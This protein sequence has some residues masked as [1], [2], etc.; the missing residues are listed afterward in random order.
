MVTE[1][2]RE[3]ADR[4]A[5][6]FDAYEASEG[7]L[8]GLTSARR[9]SL[10][11]QLVDSSRVGIYVEHLRTASLSRQATDVSDV[12]WFNPIKAAIIR[13]REGDVNEAF[14]L[15]FLLTHFG[16]HRQARWRYVREVHGALGSGQP[17]TWQRVSADVIGFRDWL[18]THRQQ[19]NDP[20]LPHGFGNHRKYES[21]AGW[22]DAG[23]G[24][25]VASY[26]AWVGDPPDHW[27][28]FGEAIAV[29]ENDPQAA[30]EILYRSMAAVYRFGRLARFD[31]LTMIGRIGL[32]DIHA[33]HAYL[34]GSTGPLKA[35]RMLFQPAGGPNMAA[36]ALEAKAAALRGYL[37]VTFAVLEDAL[38]NWQKS[39]AHFRRFRG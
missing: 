17:W 10:I 14:W 6:G 25:V 8:P 9:A 2:Q 20:A 34:E 18:D 29:A 33:G 7:P 21:L 24:S 28:R 38:C 11:Q 37:G 22:T 30:F 39:P 19:L 15:I 13:H 4:L 36:A 35:A 31:Y 26:I 27:I 12:E 3:L 16:K 32:A 23:T 1:R 5:G